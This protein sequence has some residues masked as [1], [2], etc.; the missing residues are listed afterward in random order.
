MWKRGKN[1]SAKDRLA[2][3]ARKIALDLRAR[4]LDEFVVLHAGGA[5]RHAGHA[6]QAV[7]HVLSKAIIERSLPFSGLL[8]HVDA[9]A[10]RIHLLAPQHVGGASGQAEAAMHA[11]V[12]VFLLWSM[13]CVEAGRQMR[14]PR[15]QVGALKGGLC[16]CGKANELAGIVICEAGCFS[17][18][19]DRPN[20]K[21]EWHRSMRRYRFGGCAD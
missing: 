17:H 16:Q 18:G 3:T 1:Q 11:V 21:R 9:S 15:S 2:P 10:R 8:D 20:R 6:T 7:I 14:P 19:G 12:Q 4:W 13:V 5:R